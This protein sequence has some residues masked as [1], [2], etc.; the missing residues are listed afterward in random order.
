VTVVTGATGHV[1]N[2]LVRELARRGQGIRAVVH[3]A[4]TTEA[5]TDLDVDVVRADV[6][7]YDS[8]LTAFAAP[9]SY[10]IS[11]GSSASPA[12]RRGCLRR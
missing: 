4:E 8:L 10:T 6:R 12:G 5:I 11:P 1:G 9:T 2:V 3:P 7:D